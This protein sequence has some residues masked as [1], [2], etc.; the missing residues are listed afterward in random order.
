MEQAKRLQQG[1]ST[2]RMAGAGTFARSGA[3]AGAVST[4]VFTIV[5]HIFISNIWFSLPLMLVAG[6]LCGLGIGWSYGLLA[7]QPSVRSWLGHNLVYVL[8]LMLLGAASAVMFEPVVS[9]AALMQ[10]NGPPEALIARALPVTLLFTLASSIA[11]SLLYG[12]SWRH[13]G[14]SLLTTTALVLL[15]GLNISALGLVSIPRGSFYLVAEFL[16]LVV[17]LAMVYVVVFMA[18]ARSRL[19]IRV[20]RRH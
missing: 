15:L 13:L 3:I 10:T 17:L 12:R 1:D 2:M 6:I 19:N 14:A 7:E 20:P 9:M 18:L 5:H 16:G 8:M 11:I 4:L